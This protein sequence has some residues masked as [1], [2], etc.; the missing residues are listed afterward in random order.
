[1]ASK[2]EGQVASRIVIGTFL[3]SYIENVLAQKTNT[4]E[5][6]YFVLR[7][8]VHANQDRRRFKMQDGFKAHP[9]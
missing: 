5:Y 2:I 7:I 8:R 9:P 6:M 1:M 3:T 4:S